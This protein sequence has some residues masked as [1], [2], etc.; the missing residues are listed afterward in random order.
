MSFR[1]QIA[2]LF[3]L[4][5]A[6]CLLTPPASAAPSKERDEEID[7]SHMG[8]K[9]FGEPDEKSGDALRF[10][11]PENITGNPEEMG[12]YAEGD[13]LFV[14]SD[15]RNGVRS[16]SKRWPNGRVPYKLAGAFSEWILEG[17]VLIL[18]YWN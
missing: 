6:V 5:A 8:E 11:T 16:P 13:I 4:V 2:V 12:N 18:N 1:N 10:L 17:C 9:I 7:L 3:C 15:L 14:K